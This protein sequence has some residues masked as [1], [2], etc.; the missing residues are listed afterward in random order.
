[1]PRKRR[2]AR[3]REQPEPLQPPRSA[4]PLSALRPGFDVRVVSG[5]KVYW[6]P[7]CDLEIRAGVQ[8]FVVVPEDVP[9]ARR[10]WHTGCWERELRR[11]LGRP[12]GR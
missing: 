10:H 11:T 6:C 9:G 2:A 5:D 8:H 7:G 4:A 12:R 1:M 3:D